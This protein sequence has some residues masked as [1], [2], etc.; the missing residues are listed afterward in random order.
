[1]RNLYLITTFMIMLVVNLQAQVNTFNFWSYWGTYTEISGGTL[2]DGGS[3]IDDNCYNANDIGFPFMFNGNSYTQFSVN[4]NGFIAF[5]NTVISSYTPI[6]TGVSNNVI[7]ANG[8]N[9]QGNA[10]ATLRY[11]LSGGAGNRI[12]TIQWKDFRHF[13]ET[14]VQYN[15]QIKLFELTGEI[16]FVY[17]SF[18]PGAA[19]RSA[20]VG[21]RGASNA[22]FSNRLTTINWAAT[23]SGVVNTAI[24]YIST[25][26][27]PSNGFT[28][29]YTPSQ[30]GFPGMPINPD[31]LNNAVNIPVNG[32][33][34]WTFGANTATY[35]L[36][37][38]PRGNMVKVVESQPAITGQYIYN[39]LPL[40]TSTVYHWQVTEHNASGTVNGHVWSFTTVCGPNPVP[41]TENFDGYSQP[42]VGCGTILNVNADAVKWI[43]K[44]G[45][46]Y[47]GGNKLHIGYNPAGQPHNDWYITPE[48]ALT[49]Q[50]SYDVKFFYKAG[51]PVYIE[52]LEVTWGNTPTV[53]GMNNGPVFSDIGFSQTSYT[54]ASASF[55]PPV[56][57]S[58]YIGWHC[59]SLGDQFGIDV[60]Q[61]TVAV[62][63]GVVP[64]L[65]NLQ[66]IIVP[67]EATE[68]YDAIQTI[69]IAGNGTIFSV[70]TGGSATMIAGQNIVYLPGTSVQEGGYLSGF[71][72]TTGEFCDGT[73]L[74]APAVK[75]SVKVPASDQEY[76][77]C[78]LFPNPTSGDFTIEQT[79]VDSLLPTQF[80]IFGMHGTKLI[81]EEFMNERAHRVSAQ[82]LLPGIYFI[83]VSSGNRTGCYKLIK[84]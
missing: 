14:G 82:V 47:T 54:M 29:C 10:N 13:G 60:D 40:T 21:L 7:S 22:D 5:G 27:F 42:A 52:N 46:D 31:P 39:S 61:I 79:G 19:T 84:L 50:Q 3:A 58:W 17:G 70:L 49:G 30:A 69:S 1:M 59:F 51:S 55:I 26:C 18:V 24:C 64:V 28:Y 78:K 11:Q 33:V 20:Q 8:H 63:P 57:G 23:T 2:L 6:S 65:S 4:A 72:T 83:R 32:S 66:N 35:D 37:F 62:T 71:I 73:T 68:C 41:F 45:D 80:E 43:T 75:S 15:F 36:W 12:L 56:T 81:S 44:T 25:A 34:N 16:W 9:L 48:L 67:E 53:A 74:P 38:G 77:F 76:S